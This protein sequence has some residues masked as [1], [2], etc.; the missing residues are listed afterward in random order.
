MIMNRP[1]IAAAALALAAAS[2]AFTA[3][4]HAAT[5]TTSEHV[6]VTG[7]SWWDNDPPGSAEIAHP[8]WHRTAGG[9]GTYANPITVAV[10][11]TR[12]RPNL[13][14]GTIVYLPWLHRYGGIEDTCEACT[15]HWLDWWTDARTD[16]SRQ[17]D[18]CMSAITGTH[19]VLI[20]A[21]PGYRVAAGPICAGGRLP[22]HWDEKARRA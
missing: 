18:A 11:T 7:Y 22:R 15:G 20:H 8:V 9:I 6:Y 16:T 2:L 5:A 10:G 14:F 12:G 21:G 1:R 19:S 13:P 17:A 3:P 4:A